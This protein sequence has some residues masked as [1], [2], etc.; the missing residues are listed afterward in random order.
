MNPHLL[1]IFMKNKNIST[2]LQKQYNK[3]QS[4]INK[5]IKSGKFYSYTAFKQQ[6]LK[7]R[8]QR[9]ALQLRQLATGVAVSAALVVAVPASAQFVPPGFLMHDSTSNPLEALVDAEV[10]AFGST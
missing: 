10:D 5:A 3:L 7:S 8:L 4:R 9:Y 1:Y 2:K 6:Q